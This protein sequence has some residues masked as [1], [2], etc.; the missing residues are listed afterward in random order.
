MTRLDIAVLRGLLLDLLVT[1]DDD[2]V[3]EAF[4]VYA[5]V[6]RAAIDAVVES[7]AVGD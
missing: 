2:E 3:E 7:M 6:R 5:R 4:E 1:G